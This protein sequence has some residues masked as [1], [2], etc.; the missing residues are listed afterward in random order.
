[1]NKAESL[2]LAG[3]ILSMIK[4]TDL[5]LTFVYT[6]YEGSYKTAVEINS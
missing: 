1:V 3:I 6:K 2:S 4:I 5:T